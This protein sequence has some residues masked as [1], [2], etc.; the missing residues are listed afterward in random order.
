MWRGAR[1]EAV[2]RFGDV[3]P[4]TQR[5]QIRGTSCGFGCVFSGRVGR[6]H[7]ELP[8]SSSSL[9][10]GEISRGYDGYGG[11]VESSASRGL[12]SSSRRCF[13]T[14]VNAVVA[15]SGSSTA[16][17]IE[18]EGEW[19]MWKL[20]PAVASIKRGGIVVVPTDSCYA[21]VAGLHNKDAVTKLYALKPI[22][23][24]ETPKPLSLICDSLSQISEYTTGMTQKS[25]FKLLKSLLPGP[26]T[27]ILPASNQ[28]PRMVVEHKDHKK[29]WRRKEIGVRIPDEPIIQQLVRLVGEPVLCSS[30]PIS[31][32]STLLAKDGS[33]ILSGWSGSVNYIVDAGTRSEQPSTVVD[34]TNEQTGEVKIIREGKG[35]IAPFEPYIFE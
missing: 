24:A 15:K 27:F 13:R 5:S 1:K 29:S 30:V 26:Y 12:S 18:I 7:V 33:E 8:S 35:D 21:F 23:N 34:M 6:H 20:D 3:R 32:H 4:Q 9:F 16:E 14:R 19:D 11:C 25:T 17:V 31:R 2:L 22:Q 10:V 28:L